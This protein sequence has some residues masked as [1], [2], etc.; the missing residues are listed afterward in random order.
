MLVYLVILSICQI[1]VQLV[2]LSIGQVLLVQLVFYGPNIGTAQC[3]SQDL[4]FFSKK[5]VI[6][7]F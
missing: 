4:G 6:E 7:I 1:L 2:V 5:G 3:L